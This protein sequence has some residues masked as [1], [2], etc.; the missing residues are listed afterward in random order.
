MEQAS[1]EQ[2][3]SDWSSG[4]APSATSELFKTVHQEL[5]SGLSSDFSKGFKA[6]IRFQV[7]DPEK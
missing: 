1:C 7:Q 3:F 5:G 6:F 2:R 4:Q